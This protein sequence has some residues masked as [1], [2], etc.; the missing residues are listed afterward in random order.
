VAHR[1]RKEGQKMVNVT[2]SIDEELLKKAKK[3]AIDM[4]VTISDLFRG[5]LAELTSRDGTRREFVANELDGLFEKSAASSG[6]ATWTREELHD[7]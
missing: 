4:E 6:G 1:I 5:F 7:R 2:M 3:I